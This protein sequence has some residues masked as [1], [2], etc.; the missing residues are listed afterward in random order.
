M[1]G[2]LNAKD[3]LSRKQFLVSAALAGGAAL[4]GMASPGPSSS[5][6]TG[7]FVEK[8]H[9]NQR[10]IQDPNGHFKIIDVTNGNLLEFSS[11]GDGGLVLDHD[12]GF[13]INP[14]G[15]PG[16]GIPQIAM[17]PLADPQ[18]TLLA[19]S[20]RSRSLNDVLDQFAVLNNDGFSLFQIINQTLS[21]DFSAFF[22]DVG[23]GVL[24]SLG[25]G[26]GNYGLALGDD[27]GFLV[28]SAVNEILLLTGQNGNQTQ[29]SKVN[30][31]TDTLD[32]GTN[33]GYVAGTGPFSAGKVDKIDLGNPIV[34][35][36]QSGGGIGGLSSGAQVGLPTGA[37]GTA[38]GWNRS[39]HRHPF[40][41]RFSFS[42][43]DAQ[44]ILPGGAFPD[45][46][47]RIKLTNAWTLRRIW[48]YTKAGPTG[49]TETYGLVN[50]AGVLQGT[51]VVL[52][53][54]PG[55]SQAESALQTTNLTGGTLYYLA[56]TAAGALVTIAST[57]V[58]V[59]IEYTMNI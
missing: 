57:N 27:G 44:A 6:F 29:T 41:G 21:E 37:V 52:P 31:I 35:L 12:L 51:A 11:A 56:Q 23:G 14:T 8:A 53:A 54:G 4:V 39:D 38:K 32:L 33:S 10:I 25:S 55:V 18:I 45:N 26:A 24:T 15:G 46:F 36:L 1:T 19:S 2:N 28:G 58:E 40:S 43:T 42:G 22:I 49:G 7:A 59:G 30:I 48:A 47:A 13:I 5:G 16:S 50:A 34:P 9:L 3:Q 20:G 17:Q